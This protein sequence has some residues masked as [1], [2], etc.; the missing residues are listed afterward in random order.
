MP[1][2]PCFAELLGDPRNHVRPPPPEV[3]LSKVRAA[4]DGRLTLAP[5]RAVHAVR[6][7]DV[8]LPDRTVPCRLYH[9]TDT[10]D[11]PLILFFHGGGWVW[12]NLDSHES[13]C[14]SLALEAE[15]A[16]LAVDYRLAPEHPYPAALNDAVD[17]LEWV[18]A[19]GSTLGLDPARIALCGDSSGANIALET[20]LRTSGPL[21]HLG[22]F[23]PPTDP[24]CGSASQHL[25]ANDHLLTR[26]AMQ[27]FWQ[28]YGRQAIT[29][30]SALPSTSI[31]LA[32]CDIL[33]DEGVALAD[34]MAAN[35]IAVTCRTYPGMIHAFISLP[36]VTPTALV[37]L[38][39]MGSDVKAAMKRATT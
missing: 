13:V 9:P 4:A 2:D 8:E 29:D 19:N 37:A 15:C 5:N 20:A 31:G 16:L 33:H 21:T 34:R 12:G 26:E 18:R 36:H 38:A 23:Y 7:I 35:D 3:P 27:W 22:L 1:V 6:A 17:V 10:P 25:Y 24:A 32:E 11:L 28:M 14:R 39:N 30:V